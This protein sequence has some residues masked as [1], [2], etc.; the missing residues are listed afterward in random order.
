MDARLLSICIGAIALAATGFY[1]GFKFCQKRNYL[2]GV[3]WFAL[4]ISSSNFMAYELT[5][6]NITYLGVLFL[7]TF[8]RAFG[9]PIVTVAGLMVLTHGLRP[10]IRT[11]V[12]LFGGT[13]I[14]TLLLLMDA[15]APT[16]PYFLLAMWTVFTIYLVYFAYRLWLLGEKAHAFGV[17]VA[18]ASNQTIAYMY[19]FYKIPGNETNIILNFYTIALFTWAYLT[20][21]IYYSYCAMQRAVDAASG[22]VM[23]RYRYS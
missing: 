23:N 12:L 9:L 22:G 2:I 14:A 6:A 10:A 16:L 13:A 7:D 8:S 11:D 4:A 15:M 20:V 17:I 18:A 21:Q 3:E 5:H 1:Y 19:D